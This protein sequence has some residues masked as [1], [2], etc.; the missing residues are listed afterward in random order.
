MTNF[1]NIR[2]RRLRSSKSIRKL[3]RETY[4]SPTDFIYPIF[5]TYGD[6]IKEE[7]TSM[8]GCYRFSL[9]MLPSEIANIAELD[10]SGVLLFGIPPNKDELGSEAYDK[11]GII[12]QA[13]KVIKQT[14]QK[15]IVVTDVCLCEYTNH[16]HCGITKGSEIENDATLEILAKVALSHAKAGADIVAPSA[17][18]DGQVQAIRKKLDQNGYERLLIMGYSAKYASTFY[19]P[20]RDAA[21]S[22]PQIG[23]RFSYQMDPANSNQALREVKTDISEGADIIMVKPALSYM[24]IISKVK[25][26]TLHPLAV[27]NVSGE[28]SIIKAAAQNGWIDEDKMIME[29]LTSIKRAGADI[30]ITYHAKEAT[31]LLNK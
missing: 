23:D 17:M 14:N 16:G 8:P 11:N 4:L 7:I 21:D 30:I 29:I 1:P 25:T 6:N 24:D 15:L 5:V 10:I 2:L 20:F 3:I 26:Q 9:D 12:Q 22:Q 19:G 18:M 28:Y 13:I 31:L 27:Y